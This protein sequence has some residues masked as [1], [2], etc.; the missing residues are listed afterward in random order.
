MPK[1]KEVIEEKEETKNEKNEEKKIT[2]KK[3]TTK[4]QT[5]KK[6]QTKDELEKKDDTKSKTK[7]ENTKKQIKS[8]A[9]KS[10][11]NEKETI[12]EETKKENKSK[13]EVKKETKK[14][15]IV[16]ENPKEL[17]EVKLEKIEEEIK[18]QTTIPDEKKLKINKK[19]FQ[20]IMLAIGIVIYFIFINLGFINLEQSKFIKDLQV[21]SIITIGITIIIFETAYK[22]DSGELAIYGIEFLIL[23]ICTLLT[24]FIGINYNNKLSY[25]INIIAILFAIYY[26]GK[27]IIIYIKLRKKALKRVSDI[28]KIGRVK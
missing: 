22:K 18:K 1:K 5:N 24:I 10:K 6:E 15:L 19:I 7:K 26:V 28:N 11:Q 20:N 21:F 27:S 4:K 25:I 23:S 12:K 13:E 8:T 16:K 2:K 9:S 14:E 17:D 3:T